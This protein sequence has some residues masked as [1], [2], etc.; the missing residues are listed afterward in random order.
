MEKKYRILIVD[1]DRTNLI[2]LK[3][4]IVNGYE[5]ELTTS[6][7]GALA[8]I[9][10]FNPDVLLLD[11]MMPGIDGYEV[12]R[13]IRAL[14]RFS[15]LK[16]IMLSARAMS[17]EQTKGFE[18]GADDYIIKPYSHDEILRKIESIID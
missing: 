9:D 12:C 10:S 14:E 7:E 4:I 8:A 13:K 17:D 18:A 2:F 16:I 3:E 5:M 11:V 6:G 1:D 15:H